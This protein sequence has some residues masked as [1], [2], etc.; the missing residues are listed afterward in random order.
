[1]NLFL[2]LAILSAII[3]MIGAVQ[4]EFC[5]ESLSK[6]DRLVTFRDTICENVVSER[7]FKNKGKGTNANRTDP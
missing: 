7:K 2:A 3:S 4:F 6:D 5:N 1:M